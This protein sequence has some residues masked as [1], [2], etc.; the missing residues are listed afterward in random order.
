MTQVQDDLTVAHPGAPGARGGEPGGSE[1]G[2]PGDRVGRGLA[3]NVS[4]VGEQIVQRAAGGPWEA[5]MCMWMWG[6]GGGHGGV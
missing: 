5:E 3:R 1:K 4:R 2:M 6:R